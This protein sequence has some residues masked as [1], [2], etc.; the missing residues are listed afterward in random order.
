[1]DGLYSSLVLLTVPLFIVTANIMNA[2]TI[3]DQLL[4]IY[5]ALV[6]RS[7][8]GLE[9]YTVDRAKSGWHGGFPKV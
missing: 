5:F 6:G 3:S 1:M 9:G 2:G 4:Q 8:G 7:L